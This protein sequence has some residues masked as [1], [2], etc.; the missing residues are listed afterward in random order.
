MHE[1]HPLGVVLLQL[2]RLLIKRKEVTLQ[3]LV[4]RL[5]IERKQ[6]TLQ[7]LS[8]QTKVDMKIEVSCAF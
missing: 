8:P 7:V 3:V 1:R 5:L 4:S 6:V 2:F